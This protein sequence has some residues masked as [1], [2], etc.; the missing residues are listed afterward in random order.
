VGHSVIPR[1]VACCEV[2]VNLPSF[3][4][5]AN[6][7]GD[8]RDS[9]FVVDDL[10]K[11]PDLKNRPYVTEFPNGRYYA[12]VPITSSSGINIGAYCILDDQ[13][14]VGISEQDLTFMRDM[15]QTVM[16]HLETVR[17]LSE[18][19]Q[20]NQM[21][22]GLGD[23]VRNAPD[24]QHKGGAQH[25]ALTSTNMPLKD[26]S[27]DRDPS[28]KV[29]Y[30]LPQALK[31]GIASPLPQTPSSTS[32]SYFDKRTAV[33]QQ[34]PHD[35][36]EGVP[37]PFPTS[38]PYES[39]AS[40]PLQS[41]L[42]LPHSRASSCGSA[43]SARK[44]T[45]PRRRDS[46]T[47]DQ[48]TYQRAAEI[49]CQS[50][51]IDGVAF[52]DMSIDTY[53]GL[54]QSVDSTT[55]DSSMN[56]ESAHDEPLPETNKPC[57][58]LGC[59]EVVA[60]GEVNEVQAYRNQHAKVLTETFVRRL[61]KRNPNGKIWSF[62]ED[63]V[64]HSEDGYSTDNASGDSDRAG[65]PYTPITTRRKSSRRQR[66][67]D[68]ENLQ[69][70]FPGARCIALHGIWDHARHRWSVAS[71]YWTFDPLRVLSPETEMH[72]VTAFSDIVVAETRR[73]EASTSDRSK[74]DFISSVSHELR[75]P[76]HGILGSVEILAGETLDNTAATLVEQISSCGH[77]L[78]EII[79]HLLDFSNL[80]QQNLAK[81]AVKSSK[82]GRKFLPSTA[83]ISENDL[84]S[85]KTGV[86]LDDLTEDA[87]ISSAYSYFYDHNTEDR[88]QTSVILDIDRSDN[89]AWRCQ[90][91]TGGWKRVIIN[92]VTNALKY[93]PAGFVRVSLRRKAKPGV[94]WR[95]DAVLS[96][97]DSGKG[98]SQ[99]FQKNHLFQCF[100]QED[101]LSSGL[102]LG[103]HMVDRIVNAMGGKV[104]VAS[105]QKGSG[106]RVTVTVPLENH[107]EF[108]ASADRGTS[109]LYKSM[110][111]IVKVAVLTTYK[112]LPLTR[113][114]RRVA[115]TWT[116]AIASVEK[117]LK[118]LG[119]EPEKCRLEDA[120]AYDLNIVLD[121][122]LETCLQTVQEAGSEVGYAE[123]APML[124]I[125]HNSPSAQ[126]LRRAWP[127]NPLS[128]KV[129]VDFIALPCGVRQIARSVTY[130]R[131]LR[132]ELN[133][134]PADLKCS[135]HADENESTAAK[136][137]SVIIKP[138]SQ[139]CTRPASR[140][141]SGDGKLKESHVEIDVSPPS[142]Q[143]GL[144]P[145][146]K[147]PP[148]T[149]TPTFLPKHPPG[150]SPHPP[151]SPNLATSP[152]TSLH[153]LPPP[154]TPSNP[155][156]LLVDDNRINLQ[157][158][159]AFAKKNK[160][161][162]LTALDG[163]IALEAFQTSHRESL[164]PSDPRAT[165]ATTLAAAGIP[166][167]IIMDINM[168]IMDGYE[169]VQR[170]RT[171]EAKHHMKPARIIAVTALQSEAAQMEAFGS[172]F[173]M[174]LS[175][176]IKLKSLARIIQDD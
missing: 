17:A 56:S 59:A 175:K 50:L 155:T 25:E 93:T 139:P 8:Y 125:C 34:S 79:D 166:T 12:G 89:V 48:S 140:Q 3:A 90:L 57:K 174:F 150:T 28:R 64:T 102:G 38:T 41:P 54:V 87:V 101:T 55:E 167:V 52:L 108:N 81:G 176:P 128:K 164:H 4:A 88:I 74:S 69:R 106:T 146:E 15:S 36:A 78:L 40:A 14:R 147:F 119:L 75:S 136:T 80:R 7:H 62:G 68:G 149:T 107:P 33:D 160:Y 32:H 143:N 123:V 26:E 109:V 6:V 2:T 97:T 18:R 13:P 130:T 53:C 31:E 138:E 19:E 21:V 42:E 94:R 168:P 47:E 1:D 111:D 104:D 124:V 127:E 118:F 49:M 142:G 11:H 120:K 67:G 85:M 173:D 70:A 83:D 172:G 92:L 44:Q 141:Y 95:F 110:T 98:M 148:A 76:L 151:T 65:M 156:L 135:S 170:I 84:S 9:V 51:S 61:L 121:I 159:I 105:D 71:L 116:M 137:D 72:F 171:Y 122:D 129:A 96:V 165:L 43:G 60:D 100:S 144:E 99:D 24:W 37:T 161:R 82:I 16:T 163:K 114:D 134:N 126:N 27:G 112:S 77:S 157:L 154:L 66:R 169:A 133:E 30:S 153:E 86:S 39:L 5:T 145:S 132:K 22:A 73:L 58:V 115:T 10:T 131:N 45:S 20:N 23:F 63:F 91:A 29:A 113:N 162:Y 117:N 103:L 158:L 35:S 46:L 152:A